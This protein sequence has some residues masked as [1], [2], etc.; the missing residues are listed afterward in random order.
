MVANITFWSLVHHSC[1]LPPH[2]Y[3]TNTHKQA[4]TNT[5]NVSPA[6][7]WQPGMFASPCL[8]HVFTCARPSTSREHQ[9]HRNPTKMGPEFGVLHFCSGEYTI[10][11]NMGWYRYVLRTDFPLNLGYVVAMCA[12]P[13]YLFA[14]F[15][16]QI[17]QGMICFVFFFF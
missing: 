16:Y 7:G 11:H 5:Y 2:K 6:T 4:N 1:P 14:I 17:S 12:L 13:E 8:H 9:L 10:T 3:T 15:Y